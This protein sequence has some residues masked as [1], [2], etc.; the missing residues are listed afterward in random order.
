MI[1]DS[2]QVVTGFKSKYDQIFKPASLYDPPVQVYGY[3]VDYVRDYERE[4]YDGWFLR[5]VFKEEI[6]CDKA[7]HGA[8]PVSVP[9]KRSDFL[10]CR[11]II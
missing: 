11:K 4:D 10:T 8:F 3:I 5:A 2:F 7:L 9:D 1:F 6:S